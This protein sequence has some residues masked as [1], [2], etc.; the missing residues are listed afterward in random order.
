MEVSQPVY[1]HIKDVLREEIRQGKYKPGDILPSVNQLAEMFATSR[2]T[3]VKAVSDLAKEAAIHCVQGK[4][5]IVS[6]LKKEAPTASR[7]R[8]KNP[9]MPDIGILL[10]DFDD[11]NHPYLARILRGISQKAK[12]SPCNLKTFCI[13]NY[14]IGN[15]IETESFDGLIVLTELPQSSILMLKQNAVPFVLAGNDLYG[16]DIHCVT[17]DTFNATCEAVRYLRSLGHE[18]IA[19]LSGP[20]GAKSTAVAHTAYLKV[21]SDLGLE[22]DERLFRACEWGEDGGRATFAAMLDTGAVPDAVYALEDFIALGAISAAEARGL[23]VPENLSIIGTGAMLPANNMK[24]SLTT[25]DTKLEELGSLCL[26]LLSKQLRNE[27]VKNK[28][29][30]LKPDLIKRAS[31]TMNKGKLP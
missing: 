11:I 3:A 25:F 15:F 30:N 17:A 21:M 20:S 9:S 26:D 5:S 6:D 28:K 8:V 27:P 7:K 23:S 1:Q 12:E 4:G 31:C 18:K 22:A 13:S 14:S 10:A 16:E 2:N 29:T 24:V 19:V